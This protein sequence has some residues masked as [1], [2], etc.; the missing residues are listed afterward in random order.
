MTR[1]ERIEL[2]R[3][4]QLLDRQYSGWSAGEIEAELARRAPVAYGNWKDDTPAVRSRLRQ[5][6]RWRRGGTGAGRRPRSRPPYTFVWPVGERQRQSLEPTFS[7]RPLAPR[8]SHRLFVY[9]C[10]SETV[11]ELHVKLDGVKVSYEPALRAAGFAEIHW[12]RNHVIRDALLVATEHQIFFHPVEVEFA[13]SNGAKR[14]FLK[15]VLRLDS[16]DGWNSF[17]ADDRTER[18]IE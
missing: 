2:E 6:Q 1:A 15:G 13:V 12:T 18:E 17:R 11:R 4:V 5:V 14:A 3:L 16:T 9:N 7:A 10:S 8:A